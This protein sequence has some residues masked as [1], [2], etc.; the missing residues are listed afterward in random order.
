M[1][2]FSVVSLLA[3]TVNGASADA[4]RALAL[5][6]GGSNGSWEAGIIWGLLH[7]GDQADY[8]WDVVTGVS[9]GSIN[10]AAFAG[11]DV[12]TEYEASEW[13]SDLWQ[14]LHTSDVW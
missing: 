5:S 7:Y 6:G 14:N 13:L 3:L 9:A 11:W 1:R 2:S 10:T 12:G 4:C 8:T